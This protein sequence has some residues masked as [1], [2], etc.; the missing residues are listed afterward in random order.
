MKDKKLIN[1]TKFIQSHRKEIFGSKYRGDPSIKYKK[2]I[3]AL[4][5]K[6]NEILKSGSPLSKDPKFLLGLFSFSIS[7]FGILVKTNVED[8]ENEFYQLIKD[9]VQNEL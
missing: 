4:D 5:L 6:M 8:Y 1:F 7:Q 3:A 2:Q 9:V